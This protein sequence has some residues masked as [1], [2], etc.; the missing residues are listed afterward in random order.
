MR[1]HSAVILMIILLSFGSCSK[2]TE[3]HIE[4]DGVF[5]TM[6]IK[7]GSVVDVYSPQ[8]GLRDDASFYKSERMDFTDNIEDLVIYDTS[9]IYMEYLF[10]L[11][12]NNEGVITITG[13]IIDLNG[14]PSNFVR[15]GTYRIK[16]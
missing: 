10:G 15:A 9:G 7:K 6:Q 1:I 14:N 3:V 5:Q 13:A 11:P 16:E 2:T 4:A 12:E 8:T